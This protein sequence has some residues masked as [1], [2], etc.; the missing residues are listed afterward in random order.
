MDFGRPNVEIG[1]KMANGRL[2]FLGCSLSILSPIKF[3]SEVHLSIFCPV[4][5]LHCAVNHTAAQSCQLESLVHF[6]IVIL[7]T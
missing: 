7:Y 2:L 4:K 3:L 6:V 5:I 1:R